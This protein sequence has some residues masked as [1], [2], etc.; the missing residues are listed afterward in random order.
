MARHDVRGDAS[1]VVLRGRRERFSS[2]AFNERTDNPVRALK[3]SR[4]CHVNG[5]RGGSRRAISSCEAR[6]ELRVPPVACASACECSRARGRTTHV[7]LGEG[8][9]R[10]VTNLKIRT[11]QTAHSDI[12]G[13]STRH[14]TNFNKFRFYIDEKYF[15]NVRPAGFEPVPS[16]CSS[17]ELIRHSRRTSHVKF[18]LPC[19]SRKQRQPIPVSSLVNS[20]ITVVGIYL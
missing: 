10:C 17:D 11:R 9:N 14:D 16:N 19:A 13:E 15:E 20:S 2:A 6:F 5:D 18:L 7:A 8:A 12:L 3:D 4:E 1:R